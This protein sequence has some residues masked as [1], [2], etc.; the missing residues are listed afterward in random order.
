MTA[1]PKYMNFRLKNIDSLGFTIIEMVAVLF[2]LGVISVVAVVRF[3]S[4]THSN[5][6]SEAEILKANLRYTQI[7][8]MSDA[9]TSYGGSNVKW[10]ISISGTAYTLQKNGSSTGV[11]FLNE[12]SA[13][14]NMPSGI[15]VTSG[16]VSYDVWGRPVD[17]SLNPLSENITIIVTDGISSQNIIILKNTGFIE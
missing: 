7:R 9:D 5:V 17:A 8:A 16:T 14:H 2:I 13:T 1:N 15:Q 4:T 12:N 10:G 6:A 3:T 11:K